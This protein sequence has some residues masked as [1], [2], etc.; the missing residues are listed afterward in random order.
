MDKENGSDSSALASR[1][2]DRTVSAFR[3][4]GHQLAWPL[5]KESYGVGSK[6]RGPAVPPACKGRWLPPC[7]LPLVIRCSIMAEIRPDAGIED[8][9]GF[10]G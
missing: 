2:L 9:V 1:L 6:V 4:W 7:I 5:G 10:A 8:D 3:R